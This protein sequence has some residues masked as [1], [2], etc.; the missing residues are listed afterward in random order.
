MSLVNKLDPTGARL[1]I[2][3]LTTL[4]KLGVWEDA[5]SL[6]KIDLDLMLVMLMS[7]HDL[8]GEQP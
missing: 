5:G 7:R 3:L 4:S 1:Y 8:S 6:S 2:D